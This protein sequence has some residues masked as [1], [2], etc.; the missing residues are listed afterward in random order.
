LRLS[1]QS[2]LR[3]ISQVGS[4]P[5]SSMIPISKGSLMSAANGPH[6]STVTSRQL[7]LAK[8]ATE[9]ANAIQNKVFRNCISAS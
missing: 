7:R 9:K 3:P 8:I 6:R 2:R 1:C 5:N 4:Q